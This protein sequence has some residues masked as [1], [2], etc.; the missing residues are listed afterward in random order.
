[1]GYGRMISIV[2]RLAL[3]CNGESLEAIENMGSPC[4]QEAK[5]QIRGVSLKPPQNTLTL[6]IRNAVWTAAHDISRRHGTSQDSGAT[7]IHF[8]RCLS[9]ARGSEHKWLG[10]G[11]LWARNEEGH[12]QKRRDKR[13]R[14]RDEQLQTRKEEG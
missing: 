11:G 3:D 6:T 10:G 12:Y 1:M 14:R 2:I 13:E 8:E 7:I 5:H 4:V 9:R